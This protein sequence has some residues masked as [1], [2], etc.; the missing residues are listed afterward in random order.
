MT[1]DLIK[2][3]GDVI[4]DASYI[5]DNKLDII[6]V[7]PKLDIALGGGVPEGSVFVM[8]GPEKIGKTVTALTFAGMLN[9]IVTEKYTMEM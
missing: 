6:S 8:T 7:S 5:T 9:R 3:Y 4:R 2:E 1:T